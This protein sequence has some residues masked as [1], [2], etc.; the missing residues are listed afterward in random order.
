MS[1]A[2]QARQRQVRQNEEAALRRVTERLAQ[3]F[4]ELD[5]E[6]IS[7]AVHGRYDDY[8][9][10]RVREFIPVLVERGA[11]DQLRATTR[12]RA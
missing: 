8:E 3:Q 4:P 12:Y 10:S 7:R 5:E 2:V 6:Q 9:G 1:N 11:R